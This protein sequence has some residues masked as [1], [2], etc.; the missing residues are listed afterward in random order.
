MMN[1]DLPLKVR[2]IFAELDPLIWKGIWLDILDILL[3]S[4][5]MPHIWEVII[6]QISLNKKKYPSIDNSQ[7][8]KWELKAFV[9]QAV[10]SV[11]KN[12]NNETFIAEF[13]KYFSKK[14]YNINRDIINEIYQIINN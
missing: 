13:E 4:P 6:A 10:N 3:S 14:G 7:F 2:Q 1:K 12:Y 8:M 11:N 5:N 9:A